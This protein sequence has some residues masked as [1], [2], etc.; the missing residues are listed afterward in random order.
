MKLEVDPG[1]YSALAIGFRHNG[2]SD[3]SKKTATLGVHWN[4]RLLPVMVS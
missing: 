4:T 2:D 3:P 1:T